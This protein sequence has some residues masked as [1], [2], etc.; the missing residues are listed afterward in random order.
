MPSITAATT[1][2]CRR[3][4]LAVF[5]LDGTL[6]DSFGFFVANHNRL[7]QRHRFAPIAAHEVEH[8][9]GMSPRQVMRHTRLPAWRLP[10]VARDFRR[11]MQA[12]G[13]AIACF[14]GAREALHALHARGM[15]L[16]LV[17]SNS[18]QNSR[19]ILGEDCWDLLAHVECGASL[20]G[21]ARR[22]RRVLARTGVPAARHLHRRPGLRCRG[23]APGR[24]G[25]RRGGLGLCHGRG[26][27]GLQPGGMAA[28]GVR[29]AGA[30]RRLSYSGS[31][32]GL[33]SYHSRAPARCSLRCPGCS[34]TP[35][36]STPQRA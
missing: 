27:A 23:R 26:A 32:A 1:G 21:K 5:D 33:D 19:R 8:L 18:A 24:A 15:R 9:R 36:P 12:E 29:A 16:A 30:R 13:H 22:L 4:D 3:Y 11:L 25:L 34:S 28:A 6:A 14:D 35:M 10:L 20:F 7:A 2:T 31:S 17:T